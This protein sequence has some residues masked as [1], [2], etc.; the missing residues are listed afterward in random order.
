LALV[1]NIRQ[2]RASTVAYFFPLISEEEKSLQT[3]ATG[4]DK[5]EDRAENMELSCVNTIKLFYSPLKVIISLTV[6][7]WQAFY[8]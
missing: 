6:F 1:L 3:S 8:G 4:K 2:A 5:I 7:P